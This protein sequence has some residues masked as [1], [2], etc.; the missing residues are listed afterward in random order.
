MIILYR[1]VPCD[2]HPC[3]YIYIYIYI[4]IGGGE[5]SLSHFS[6]LTSLHPCYESCESS[7][8]TKTS[9]WNKSS[10]TKHEEGG[11]FFFPEWLTSSLCVCW[12]TGCS[13]KHSLHHPKTCLF[14]SRCWGLDTKAFLV[15]CLPRHHLKA[16]YV[17]YWNK[18]LIRK[19]N[20]FRDLLFWPSVRHCRLSIMCCDQLGETS[21][22][23]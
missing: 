8:T 23:L 5:F 3:V 17:H 14:K 22:W 19:L 10:Q 16:P 20:E 2:S 7:V 9:D 6:L 21:L 4:Y 15:S 12:R 18:R 1:E 11:H 13:S